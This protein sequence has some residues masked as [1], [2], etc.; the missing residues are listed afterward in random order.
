MLR[1]VRTIKYRSPDGGDGYPSQLRFWRS[2]ARYKGF[3]GPLGS[4]KT[5]ALAHESIRL[6]T[7]NPGL[8][9]L[10]A[11]PTYRMLYDVDVP[12]ILAQLNQFQIPYLHIKNSHIKLTQIGSTILLRTMEN[13]ER[14]RGP[15][16][17]WFGVDEMTY[18]KEE[19]LKR[20]DGR[21]RH[22]KATLLCGFGAWTPKGF[23]WVYSRFVD[24]A[25]R[26]PDHEAVIAQPFENTAILKSTPD[27]YEKLKSSYDEKFYQQEALGLYLNVFSGQ[28]Y[29]C[30]G[31]ENIREGGYD[32]TRP[33]FW[34]MDFNVIRESSIIGQYDDRGEVQI[35]HE[36]VL[37][38]ASTTQACDAFLNYTNQ[39]T[40][41]G[42]KLHVEVYGDAS[43]GARQ[44]AT[45][46]TDW[47]QV[48]QVLGQHPNYAPTY[49]V[50]PAN[51]PVKD[52]V[53]SMNALL[54]A[55]NGSRRLFV[56][57]S[58]AGLMTDFRQVSWKTDASGNA[59]G[60]IDKGN[61]K[62]THLSDAL[63]YFAWQK[64]G[65]RPKAGLMAGAPPI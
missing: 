54:K 8:V 45:G 9:G 64:F 3:S 35:L 2:T 42:R 13:P 36:L 5:V 56:D 40:R 52:R 41:A 43:G 6:S 58:C 37:P 4:G 65:I 12:E 17:A 20:L 62:L 55:Y 32:P 7:V 18:C 46:V 16:L 63:G 53:N 33:L 21:L 50:P 22:P 51:P 31:D 49:H 61:F 60:D 11:A 10:I 44:G 24:P 19:S 38:D 30:F 23:D 27:F 34:A 15:N 57:Q 25:R 14:L 39:W 29:Y 1:R 47:V 26:L 48:R 59:Y 28:V